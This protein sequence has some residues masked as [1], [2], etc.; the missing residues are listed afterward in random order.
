MTDEQWRR[1]R[2]HFGDLLYEHPELA[3]GMLEIVVLMEA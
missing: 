1:I 2:R 3:E